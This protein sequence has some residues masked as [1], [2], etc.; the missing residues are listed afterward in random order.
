MPEKDEICE[1]ATFVGSVFQR[2]RYIGDKLAL[3]TETRRIFR[4]LEGSS[5][6]VRVPFQAACRMHQLSL[7]LGAGRPSV[8]ASYQYGAIDSIVKSNTR[9]YGSITDFM[10]KYGNADRD[11]CELLHSKVRS[12]HWHSG[13]MPLGETHFG[14]ADMLYDPSRIPVAMVTMQSHDLM[15]AAILNWLNEQIRFSD[16]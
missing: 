1:Q 12:A 11:L 9:I 8:K 13:Y 7:I 3:P 16:D 10:T 15:R 14:G 6:A 5:D 2:R 4:R